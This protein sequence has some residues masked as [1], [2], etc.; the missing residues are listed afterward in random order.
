LKGR[1]DVQT[2]AQRASPK[3]ASPDAARFAGAVTEGI[4]TAKPSET[5]LNL[6]L[7]RVRIHPGAT[8]T[9]IADAVRAAVEA[10]RDQKRR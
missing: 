9:Q 1:P 10:G 5:T 4:A 7:L 8:E 6:G 2:G 3:I